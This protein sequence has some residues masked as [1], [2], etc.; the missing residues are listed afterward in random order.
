MAKGEIRTPGRSSPNKKKR[1]KNPKN[2]GYD[3][4]E[5]P[6]TGAS[7]KQISRGNYKKKAKSSRQYERTKEETESEKRER[8]QTAT[9]T[10]RPRHRE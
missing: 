2:P 9:M 10:A 4:E 7:T 3:P 6:A 8:K 1:Q 5:K